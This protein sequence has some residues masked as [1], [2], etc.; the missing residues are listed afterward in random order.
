MHQ[1]IRTLRPNAGGRSSVGDVVTVLSDQ[2]M[3]PIEIRSVLGADDP[4]LIRRLLEL[5]RE[6]LLARLEAECWELAR[7][8]PLLTAR[9]MRTGRGRAAP[10]RGSVHDH[11]S[12]RRRTASDYP[13]VLLLNEAQDPEK[14]R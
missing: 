4:L 6:R 8:E 1:A 12:G 2:G 7:L 3:P 10:H 14:N 5:H 9:S 11:L 13:S